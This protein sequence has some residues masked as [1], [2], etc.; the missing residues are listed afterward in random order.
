MSRHVTFKQ[1]A[2][3]YMQ[4]ATLRTRKPMKPATIRGFKCYLNKWLLPALGD[5][6]LLEVNNGKLRGLVSEMIQAGLS[7]KSIDSYIG[8]VKLIMASA[9]AENGEQL[10]PRKWNA[11]LI[12]MPLIRYK[13]T[14]TISAETVSKVLEATTGQERMLFLLLAATG[15]RIGEALGLEVKHIINDGRT[16]VIEQ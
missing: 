14:P 15:L 7:S 13:H 6:L 1:Q 10:F 12:G 9:V 3:T 2:K 5:S 16:L 4:Y 11:D 8:L